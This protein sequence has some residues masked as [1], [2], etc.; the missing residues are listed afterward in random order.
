M[1]L[2]SLGSV[3]KQGREDVGLSQRDLARKLGVSHP[4]ISKLEAGKTKS[5]SLDLL[6]RIAATLGIDRINL[7][8]YAG[9]IPEPI[10]DEVA[11]QIVARGSVSITMAELDFLIDSDEW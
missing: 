6:D 8:C 3:I 5:V 1:K 7:R 10:V 2:E 11:R 4:F 9:R